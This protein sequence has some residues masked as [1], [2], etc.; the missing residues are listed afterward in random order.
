MQRTLPPL[1][2]LLCAIVMLGWWLPNREQNPVP[3]EHAARFNSLSYG[4]YRP[5]ESPLNDHFATAAEVD[6]DMA[7]LAPITRAIRTYSA[8]EGPYEI[9][10]AAQKH[11]VKVW[12]GIWLGGDR[13]KNQVEM[14]RAI[15]MAHRYPNTIERVVVGNEVLLRRDLPADELIADIDHVK[16]NVRQPVAYGDVPDFWNQFPQVAQHVDVVLIHLLPYWE[17]VPSSIGHAVETGAAVY[18]HFTQLFPGKQVAIGETG[19]PSCCRQRRDAQPS[20]INE[21]RFLREFMA[22]AA[23]KHFD[24]NFIEAFDQHWKYENEGIVGANWGLFYADRTIKIPPSGSLREDPSW[25]LH[26]ALSIAAGLAL[27]GL[28]LSR[29]VPDAGALAPAQLALLGMTLGGALGWAWAGAVFYDGHV[30]LAAVVNLSSQALLAAL[31]MLRGAGAIAPA[32]WRTGADATNRI[33]R[34]LRFR[35]AAWPGLFEDVAFLFAWAAA[36]D[37]ILLVF[38]PRYREFPLS[39]FA[40]PLVVIAARAARGDLP[41]GNGGREEALLALTLTLG[42]IASAVQEGALNG[43]SLVWNAAVLVLAAPL[44]LAV[45]KESLLF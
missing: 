17:D 14:A 6:E 35:H 34:W 9:P 44:W 24:Y 25:L 1:L 40:V 12:Q 13:A 19:W 8:L 21:A 42:A 43:Q 31:M 2:L 23:E 4:A 28:A 38:D 33:R 22:L 30:V 11:G 32:H 36:V 37:Q 26:A 5:G 7:L 20:R 18:A 45:K 10:A 27:T 41:R 29:R 16:A 15:D 3:G 39:T